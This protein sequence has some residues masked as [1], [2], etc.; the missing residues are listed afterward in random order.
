MKSNI[1]KIQHLGKPL[2]IDADK[3]KADYKAVQA[4]SE[5]EYADEYKALAPDWKKDIWFALL[6]RI[7]FSTFVTQNL[8][9]S[10]TIQTALNVVLRKCGYPQEAELEKLLFDLGGHLIQ[11]AGNLPERPG[12]SETQIDATTLLGIIGRTFERIDKLLSRVLG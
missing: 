10:Q 1:L 8:N 9:Y 12:E 3:Y 11:Y 4:L 7:D 5:N 6:Q 2:I